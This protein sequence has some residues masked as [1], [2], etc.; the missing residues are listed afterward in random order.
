MDF[1]NFLLLLAVSFLS[2]IIGTMI[3]MAMLILPPVMIFMGIPVHVAVATARFSMVGIG[4]GNISRLSL[5]NKI[6]SKYAYPFAIA[7][8]IGAIISSSFISIIN[9]D[10]LRMIIGIFMLIISVLVLFE[11]RL[12]LI[13]RKSRITKMQHFLSILGGLF[14]GSYIGI[15]GGGGATIIIFL[16]VVI[17]GLNFQDATINQKVA[18]LPISIVTTVIFIYQGLIDYK[19]GVPLFLINII[20]GWVG[21]WLLLKINSKWLKRILLPVIVFMALKLISSVTIGK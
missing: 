19:L 7:G 8:V 4:V 13:R 14:V 5:K 3:G 6:Q 17:Y 10:W 2:S 11:E 9:E 18:T 1:I 20:G 16:L 15:V 12:S 21:A